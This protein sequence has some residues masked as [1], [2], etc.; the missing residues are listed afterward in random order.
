MPA[1]TIA[2]TDLETLQQLN[3]DYISSVQ[4]SDVRRF[5]EILAEDFLCSNPDGSLVDRAAFLAQT[6][7]PVTISNLEARDVV[8]RLLGD[9]AIIHARTTYT[10]PDGRPGMGRY[11]DVW[12]RRRGRWL[13]VSAHVTRG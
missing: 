13:A 8:V 6:A 9:V 5:D 7:R 11:T 1:E 4:T 10:L 3:R 12:A 2:Q